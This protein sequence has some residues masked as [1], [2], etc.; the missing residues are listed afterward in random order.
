MDTGMLI[1][2]KFEA[3]TETEEPILNPKTGET[4]LNLPEASQAQ[5]EA[6]VA[7]AQKAFATWS[8]TT[9]AQRSGYLLQIADAIERN[10]QD[11]AALEALNCGKP[12]NSVLN[13]E[14]PAIVDCYRF[15]AGAV[16]TMPGAIAG[17]YLPG[18]TSM[19]R[20]DAIG[21]VASIAPWNYPLMMMAWK[22]APA[23]GG[24]NTVVFKPSEQTPLTAL[25]LGKLLADILPEGVVNIVLGRGESVGN[26]L[27]NH[28]KIGMISITGD[29]ATG[30]KVLQAAAKSVKRTHLELG[31]KAPVIVFDDADVEAVV[32]GLRAFGYYNAGQDC[33]AA[34]RVYA[35][36]K[37]YDKLVADLSAAVSTIKYAQP[38]DTENEIGP[39]ISKRQRDRV[40][41][42]VERA[43]EL[44]HIEITTGGKPGE[45]NGFFYQPTVVAGALQ[46]DE[47]VRREVF[48][49]VV[50]VTRFTD[51][52]DAVAWANDSDYGLASSVWTKDVSR[53]MATASRLQYGCTWINTHFML[54]NEMPHGGLKQ[55]GYGKDM[56]LYALEDYTA[57]RHVMVAH[58]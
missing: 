27:I 19:I 31:G 45:G 52:E 29:I 23:I 16:R 54:C 13:D 48:G 37:V 36:R 2:S 28:P 53:A 20:R 47:I 50:S 5:I 14:I 1:G 33:T 56:S 39:L 55:S 25:K 49:P 41:S 15:F 26:A 43:A 6:A 57:V 9:P 51:V 4:I 46:E 3:G 32:T 42:F 7:A 18:F 24:G 21:L 17:E 35:G 44:K 8:R 22:L 34:C 40:A 12:I 11:F 58:G 30:K 10:A 38:D